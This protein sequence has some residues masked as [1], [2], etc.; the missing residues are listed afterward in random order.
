MFDRHEIDWKRGGAGAGQTHPAGAGARGSRARAFALRFGVPIAAVS[1]AALA[2][3]GT[4]LGARGLTDEF[5]RLAGLAGVG[6]HQIEI[7]GHRFAA[8]ADVLDALD[9]AFVNSLVRFDSREACRRIEQ[10]PWVKTALVAR[11]LPGRLSVTITEREAFAVWRHAGRTVLVDSTGRVLGPIAAGARPDLP[12]LAG[13]GAPAAAGELLQSL[14]RHPELRQRLLMLTRVAGRRWTLTLAGEQT[15]HLPAG[16]EVAALE[17]LTREQTG[18]PLF[19]RHLSLIDLRGQDRVV[20]RDSGGVAPVVRATSTFTDLDR[21]P[22]HPDPLPEGRGNDS[23]GRINSVI[24]SPLGQ[25][26]ARLAPG[27]GVDRSAFIKSGAA[28]AAAARAE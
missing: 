22:A 21:R 23:V 13:D 28:P 15:V 12:R 16:R 26:P 24:A 20:V 27:E 19:K 7:T 25:R 18:G 8:D 1:I 4:K 14:D 2:W 11:L 5:D 6:W 17:L 3:Q 9:A 10:L